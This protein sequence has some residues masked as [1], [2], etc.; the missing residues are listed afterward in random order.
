MDTKLLTHYIEGSNTVI[1]PNDNKNNDK[2]YENKAEKTNEKYQEFVKV[3]FEDLST[4]QLIYHLSANKEL[5]SLLNT[6]DLK[7]MKL[8]GLKM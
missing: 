2:V 4:E 7:E 1:Q 3:Q 6:E 8:N 5:K